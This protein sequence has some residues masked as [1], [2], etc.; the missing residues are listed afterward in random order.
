M[1]CHP[2]VYCR[3][4]RRRD[5]SATDGDGEEKNSHVFADCFLDASNAELSFV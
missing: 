5:K 2:P 1:T 3:P 4:V